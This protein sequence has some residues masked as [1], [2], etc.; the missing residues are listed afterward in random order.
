[1]VYAL[2]TN[3]WWNTLV[4]QALAWMYFSLFTTSE[5]AFPFAKVGLFSI[6][7]LA[8]AAWGYLL[9][10]YFDR[11]QDTKAGKKNTLAGIEPILAQSVI[12]FLFTIAVG[13]WWFTYAP[14]TANILYALQLVALIVYAVPPFRIK[15][16]G[17]AGVLTDAFYAHVNPAFI[18]LF[19]FNGFAIYT[20]I[21]CYF[22]VAALIGTSLLKGIRNILLHQIEDRKNDRRA[23]I[24]TY[25]V[26]RGG[27]YV[28]RLINKL[29][30]PEAVLLLVLVIMLSVKYPPVVVF[31]LLFAITTY[32]SFSGWKLA[33]LPKRQKL[34]KW[35]YVLNNYY[36]RWLP[37]SLLITFTVYNPAWTGL[38]LLHVLLF[39]AWIRG[40]FDDIR[41]IGEN[42]KTEENY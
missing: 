23:G 31:F 15:E 38:L 9:N 5:E 16:K 20:G 14:I 11:E 3:L 13:S 39:P 18:T 4:P 2:R 17:L 29:L 21:G 10:D 33:Y 26:N 42:F 7:L 36:E 41:T 6:S 19:L 25:T 37:V 27:L 28:V 32:L 22:F 24:Q 12:A 34:F 8:T 30:L 1:M 35:L 40:I